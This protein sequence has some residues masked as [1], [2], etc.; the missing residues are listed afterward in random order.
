MP[1]IAY[2][3]SEASRFESLDRK[4]NRAVTGFHVLWPIDCFG[5]LARSTGHLESE[6]DFLAVMIFSAMSEATRAVVRLVAI[7][8]RVKDLRNHLSL[9]CCSYAQSRKELDQA[10]RLMARPVC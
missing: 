7:P 3:P 6:T 10:I 5:A 1:V 9:L 4:V 8:E 2:L